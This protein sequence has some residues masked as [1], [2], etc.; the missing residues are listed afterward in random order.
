VTS[1]R[2]PHFLVGRQVTY[3]MPPP[4]TIY[5]HVASAVGELPDPSSFRFGYDFRF[6]AKAEDLE[7]Q[8]IISTGGAPFV[9]DGSKHRTA[10]Q[11]VVQPHIREFIFQPTLTL[12]LDDSRLADP[13]RKPVF[14]VILGRSQDLATIISV[15]EVELERAEG[16]YFEHTLIPFSVRPY[17]GV[18]STVLMPRLIGPPPERVPQFERY[19]ALHERAFAGRLDGEPAANRMIERVERRQWWVDPDTQK[20]YGVHR[21]V[22]FHAFVPTTD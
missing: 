21:A 5:G 11:G 2:Y 8:H 19:I 9:A 12:Y 22:V 3:D 4:S 14:C 10:V 7:H 16:A 6:R 1:F 15:E 13:F 17:L 20:S 18:G